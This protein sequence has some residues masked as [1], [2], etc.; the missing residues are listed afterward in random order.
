[1][2]M[3]VLFKPRILRPCSHGSA[4]PGLVLGQGQPGSAA[5]QLHLPSWERGW[6]RQ[7][8]IQSDGHL[9]RSR[10]LV[11]QVFPQGCLS[12]LSTWQLASHGAREQQT[13]TES[14]RGDRCLYDRVSEATHCY[15]SLFFVRS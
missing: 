6:Q 14:N 7:G 2:G 10:F 12:V 5:P 15:F 8:A 3:A 11:T 1:M 9:R 13:E 4:G